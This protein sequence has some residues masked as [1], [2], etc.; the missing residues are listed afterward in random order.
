[1]EAL[2]SRVDAKESYRHTWSVLTSLTGLRDLRVYIRS[3]DSFEC[4]WRANESMICEP[5]PHFPHLEVFEVAIS[6]EPE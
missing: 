2:E 1:M 6:A 5:I 4:Y 3:S